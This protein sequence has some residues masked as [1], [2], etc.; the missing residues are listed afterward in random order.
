[1]TCS[2]STNSLSPNACLVYIQPSNLF[3]AAT[4]TTT[5]LFIHHFHSP[6]VYSLVQKPCHVNSPACR[7]DTVSARIYDRP[8]PSYI[9][10]ACTNLCCFMI[11]GN[12]KTCYGPYH[13]TQATTPPHMPVLD[14]GVILSYPQ[15]S[16]RERQ[17]GSI[18]FSFARKPC[19]FVIDSCTFDLV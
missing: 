18:F 6:K 5:S 13:A 2:T 3:V 16:R 14:Y 12:F 8:D 17:A 4:T 11:V 7:H 10:R 19:F 15:L 9:A 1:M